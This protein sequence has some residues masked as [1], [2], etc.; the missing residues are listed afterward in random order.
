MKKKLSNKIADIISKACEESELLIKQAIREKLSA[1]KQ[2]SFCLCMGTHSLCKASKWL[3]HSELPIWFKDISFAIED[4]L[5][6]FG[7]I[8]WRIEW[9]D[10]KLVERTDW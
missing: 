8:T 9:I 10:G 7:T 2:Y 5:D 6:A 4:H 3:D 1:H